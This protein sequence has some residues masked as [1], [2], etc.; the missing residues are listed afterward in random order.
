M[1]TGQEK[2]EHLDYI[3]YVLPADRHISALPD[4]EVFG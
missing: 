3:K 2:E 4:Y 1:R